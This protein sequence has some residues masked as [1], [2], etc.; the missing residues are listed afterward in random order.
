MNLIGVVV[1]AEELSSA[2][3]SACAWAMPFNTWAVG[4]LT[5]LK[6]RQRSR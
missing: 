4:A 5:V 3:E 6:L 2:T 1:A